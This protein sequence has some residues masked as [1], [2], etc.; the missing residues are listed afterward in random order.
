MAGRRLRARI[1]AILPPDLIDAAVKQCRKT[2]AGSADTPLED[3]IQNMVAAF[4]KLSV[5]REMLEQRLGHDVSKSTN[6]ELAELVGIYNSIKDHLT[7]PADWFDPIQDTQ[8]TRSINDKM[9]EI[10]EH[11][12][13]V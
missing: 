10:E 13:N 4:K 9:K 2:L 1:L 5:R 8:K 7:V 12:D 11:A 6:E 3:R